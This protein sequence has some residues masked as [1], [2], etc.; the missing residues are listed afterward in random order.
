MLLTSDY[1]QI[2]IAPGKRSSKPHIRGR[3][4]TASDM[5]AYLA[6]GMS[7]DEILSDF[8]ELSAEDIHAYHAFA[9][10]RERRLLT[11]PAA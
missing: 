5:L 7:V 10:E 9:A 3:R 8:P 2:T 4:I 11:I 1:L 6:A